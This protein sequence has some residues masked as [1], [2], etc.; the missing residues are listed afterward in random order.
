MRRRRLFEARIL[1]EEPRYLFNFSRH[2]HKVQFKF[3]VI[4]KYL[5]LSYNKLGDGYTLF[6][7]IEYKLISKKELI[8]E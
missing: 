7:R 5:T 1:L 3:I 2:L 4:D 8:F 6:T